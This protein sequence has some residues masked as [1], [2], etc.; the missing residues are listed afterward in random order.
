MMLIINICKERLHYYEFV[1]PIEDILS[2][3]GEKFY[4]KHYT[5]FNDKD[6]KAD[7]IIISGTSLKDNDFLEQIEKFKWLNFYNKPILGIC[8]GMEILSLYYNGSVKDNFEIGE[9]EIRFIKDFLNFKKGQ[10]I[11]AY[12]LHSKFVEI[13]EGSFEIIAKSEKCIQVVQHKEKHFYGTMFH[14][15]VR[16]KK[17]ILEFIKNE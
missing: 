6:L 12:T 17:M 16:N 5:K 1:K 2:K 11:K 14:P 3:L 9:V 8:A 13:D 7:K 4:T 10:K 15:E